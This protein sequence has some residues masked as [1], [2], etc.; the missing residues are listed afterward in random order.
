MSGRLCQNCG[1]ECAPRQWRQQR[2]ST[3]WMWRRRHGTERPLPPPKAPPPV[4]DG[5]RELYVSETTIVK[6]CLTYLRRLSFSRW[7]TRH[8]TAYGRVGQPDIFGCYHGQHVEIEIKRPGE[9]PTERQ[10]FEREKWRAARALVG[11]AT[12][13]AE[14]RWVLWPILLDDDKEV[15]P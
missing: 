2:C 5:R 6:A 3:C 13:P 11:W 7:E 14:C 10:N 4:D 1:R 9:K 8:G 12:S 15:A